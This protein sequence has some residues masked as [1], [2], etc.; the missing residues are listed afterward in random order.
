MDRNHAIRLIAEILLESTIRK[1]NNLSFNLKH[2]LICSI[3]DVILDSYILN[4]S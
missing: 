1:V 2:C 3:K 4:S